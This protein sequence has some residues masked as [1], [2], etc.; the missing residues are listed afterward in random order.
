LPR[1]M[2]ELLKEGGVVNYYR[3]HAKLPEV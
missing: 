2:Q 1:F 3:K